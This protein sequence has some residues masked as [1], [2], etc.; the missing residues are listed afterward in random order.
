MNEREAV[1]AAYSAINYPGQQA[2][3]RDEIRIIIAAAEPHLR[4]TDV[5]TVTDTLRKHRQDAL[6]CYDHDT[7]WCC[8]CGTHEI[9]VP[10]REHTAR[11]IVA[12]LKGGRG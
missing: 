7:G 12:A 9:L 5:T 6:T 1:E 4:N 10:W 8:E 2:I 3:D 11:A